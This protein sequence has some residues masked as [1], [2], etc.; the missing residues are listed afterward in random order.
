MMDNSLLINIHPVWIY[1]ELR[2]KMPKYRCVLIC[3]SSG[4]ASRNA[5]A[6]YYFAVFDRL[7]EQGVLQIIDF[8]ASEIVSDPNKI[9][10]DYFGTIHYLPP[11]SRGP[12]SGEDLKKCDLWYD[13]LI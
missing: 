2:L 7:G 9:Y 10:N 4:L 5:R 13:Q 1:D 8:G 12:R 3:Y 11:E 6:L